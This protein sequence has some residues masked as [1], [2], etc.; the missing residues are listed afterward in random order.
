VKIA[1][2]RRDDVQLRMAIR[3]LGWIYEV[4][5]GARPARREDPRKGQNGPFKTF[6]KAAIKPLW[7]Y[8]SGSG[9]IRDAVNW[10]KK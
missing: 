8:A 4:L 6:V 5:T 1:Q 7:P 3:E 10:Y 2:G 9:Y